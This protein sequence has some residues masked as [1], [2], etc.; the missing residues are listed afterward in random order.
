MLRLS[1]HQIGRTEQVNLGKRVFEVELRP[2]HQGSSYSECVRDCP[3]GWEIP[4]SDFL[5]TLRNNSKYRAWFELL[6]TMEYVPNPD[7]VSRQRGHIAVF[8]ADHLG[9]T[10][11]TNGNEDYF[12]GPFGV[13]YFREL[14]QAKSSAQR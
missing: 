1:V 10:I 3:P 5:Q 12:R 2:H 9:V 7:D 13:R 8:I 4:S 14:S 11:H 6:S